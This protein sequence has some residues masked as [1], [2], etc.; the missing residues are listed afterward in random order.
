M[1]K[2]RLGRWIDSG[3]GKPHKKESSW[4]YF[5]RVYESIT[6]IVSGQAS[7]GMPT[8]YCGNVSGG[9]WSCLEI[10]SDL[11][12]DIDDLVEAS[13]NDDLE[14]LLV[15]HG[16]WH[17]D[18]SWAF[19]LR[20]TSPSGERAVVPFDDN[21]EKMPRRT[22]ADKIVPFGTWLY[23]HVVKLAKTMEQNTLDLNL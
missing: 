19:D 8:F 7:D 15:F 17:T 2:Q 14:D 6:W 20:S 23:K 9:G 16:G 10:D 1:H 11:Y 4:N 18:C 21:M 13:G 12:F 5:A 22:P 3:P